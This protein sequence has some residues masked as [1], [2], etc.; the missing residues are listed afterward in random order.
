MMRQS[1]V[2]KEDEIT[3]GQ[4]CV[5]AGVSRATIFA[6]QKPEVVD[7]SDLLGT[8]KVISATKKSTANAPVVGCSVQ[9]NLVFPCL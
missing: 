4:Q 7:E 3:V 5:L 2:N 1:W 6:Q 8:A 9:T